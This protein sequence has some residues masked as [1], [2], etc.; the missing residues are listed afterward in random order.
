MQWK[1][2]SAYNFHIQFSGKHNFVL[3]CVFVFRRIFNSVPINRQMTIGDCDGTSLIRCNSI[4]VQFSFW[5]FSYLVF[6]SFKSTSTMSKIHIHITARYHTVFSFLSFKHKTTD[7]KCSNSFVAVTK[8]IDSLFLLP[9]L[10]SFILL[11]L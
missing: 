6:H 9:W 7:I 5:I 2:G 1:S 8:C 11:S 3:L 10:F 4:C